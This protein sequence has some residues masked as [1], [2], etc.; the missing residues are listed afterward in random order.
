MNV[1][2]NMMVK[3]VPSTAPV[4]EMASME[5]IGRSALLSVIHNPGR[6]NASPPATIAP[7]L[8]SVCVQFIS[9]SVA[10]FA[11]PST[12]I[13]STVTKTVGHGKAPILRATYAL[14]AVIMIRPSIPTANALIVSGLLFSFMRKL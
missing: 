6:V 12:A 11:F 14:D 3:S 9:S 4:I 2:R 13:E 1:L 5:M 7:A 10:P 8:I